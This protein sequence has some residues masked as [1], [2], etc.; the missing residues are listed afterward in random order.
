MPSAWRASPRAAKAG[1]IA[2][3]ARLGDSV[4]G[5]QVLATLD[6]LAVGEAHAA[7]VQAP[8][9]LRI[10]ESDLARAESLVADEII[11]RKD[12]LRA[13]SDRDK[14]AA[15][16]RGAADRLR[17]LGGVSAA[18]GAGVSHFAVTA[19]FAGT[20]IDKKATL[21]E[22]ASPAEA[23]FS[24][25]DLSR[26]WILADL[27]EAARAGQGA[28]RRRRQGQRAGVSGEQLRRPRRPYRR[29]AGQADAHGRGAHRGAERRGAPE[30]RNVRH[31]DHRGRR[32]SGRQEA[33]SDHAARCGGGA[34]G[35]QADGLRL[36]AG[37]LR[38][39]AGQPGERIGDST[40]LKSGVTAG[41]RWWWRA[42][43]R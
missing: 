36:R 43:T 10:A 15:A 31:R 5:G 6:S 37:R 41:G 19:P 4:R 28:R 27:P 8:A 34:D 18:S 26:V 30:A 35:G 29:G 22:L 25:A 3:P 42:P 2:A 32:R 20:V 24:I 38:G 39:A 17:L 7:W 12:Y 14:A 11:P 40:V 21:G 16:L 1:I 33:R 23:M 9:E 13:Q